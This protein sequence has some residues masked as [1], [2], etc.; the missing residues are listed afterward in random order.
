MDLGHSGVRARSVPGDR[1][2]VNPFHSD[3]VQQE[4]RLLAARPSDLPSLNGSMDAGCTLQNGEVH[5]IRSSGPIDAGMTGKGRGMGQ[6]GLPPSGPQRSTGT[7]NGMRTEG[8]MPSARRIGMKFLQGSQPP[9]N[10]DG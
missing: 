10:L 6:D 5:P 7:G 3:R 8:R 9:M 1:I 4:Y 2:A